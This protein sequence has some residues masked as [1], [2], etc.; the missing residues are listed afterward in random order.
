VK[1]HNIRMWQIIFLCFIS[2]PCV[3]RSLEPFD[4]WVNNDGACKSSMK[5]CTFQLQATNAM[6]M[7]YKELFRV[8][9]TDNGIL[10]KYDDDSKTFDFDSILTGDGYPKLVRNAYSLKALYT[11]E[12]IFFVYSI[13][14]CIQQFSSWSCV[15]CLS[16]SKSFCT[17]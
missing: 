12:V 1:E 14:V 13:G 4:P 2:L 7:F 10:H 8:N 11:L 6:T 9:A 5:S 16:R 15:A 3:V 17:H